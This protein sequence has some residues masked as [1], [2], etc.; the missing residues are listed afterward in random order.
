LGARSF[1]R[2]QEDAE[3]RKT[4]QLHSVPLPQGA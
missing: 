3:F 1:A 4:F 2:D